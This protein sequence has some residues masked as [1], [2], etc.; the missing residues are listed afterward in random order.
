L[1]I[2]KRLPGWAAHPASV[3]L[4]LY[5]VVTLVTHAHLS[6][7]APLYVASVVNRLGGARDERDFWDA[8]HLIWRSIGYLVAT[9]LGGT[10]VRVTA[11][12][13]IFLGLSWVGGAACSV[14]L[15]A[16]LSRLR[17]SSEAA[18]AGTLTVMGA[19]AFLLYYQGGVAYVPGMSC[20]L[21][22]LYLLAAPE[23]SRTAAVG[24]GLAAALAVLLWLPFVCALP[25]VLLSPLL[26][27]RADRR[28]VATAA[29]A[30]SACAALG[31]GA[32]L[33]VAAHL[34]VLSPS[35]FR[36]W[37][38]DASH[39][40]T[41]VRGVSRAAFG[42]ARSFLNMGTDGALMKRYLLHD[43][44]NP[45][46]FGALFR[47][48]LYKFLLFYAILGTIAWV[49]WRRVDR[50]IIAFCLVAALPVM[51]FGVA[52]QGGDPER[53][54]ALYP[55]FALA[56]AACIS[57]ARRRTSVGRLLLLAFVLVLLAVNVPI[58]SRQAFASNSQSMLS[59]VMAFDAVTLPE[60]SMV[61]TPSW[62]D[63][64]VAY[65][66]SGAAPPLRIRG[67]L[68]LYGLMQ[69]GVEYAPR[70]RRD[71]AERALQA[72]DAGGRIWISRRLLA[73]RPDADWGWV[74]GDDRRLSWRDFPGYFTP[75]DYGATLGGPDG[76]VEMLASPGNRSRLEASS[77]STTGG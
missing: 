34:D 67:R 65:F 10:G 74:E 68:P 69:P 63:A 56:L 13:R 21:A 46:S 42:L 64:I 26:L 77:R 17:V 23:V 5:V 31:L 71:F 7:D 55:A 4:L 3:C 25:A 38:S 59:R 24:A 47:A 16:W 41:R 70:W 48:G 35:A 8:G 29:T 18:I 14:L 62:N 45:V 57:W 19:N 58:Y 27:H 73:A 54:F 22:A 32:Y 1:G 49:S 72:L 39:H 76:F 43:P 61:V 66:G 40:I 2:E 9:I 36:A 50:R 37:I 20:L 30:V 52:W 75:F 60:R 6:G 44:Y 12:G 33:A 15:P 53:Y 28:N 51:A 11:V